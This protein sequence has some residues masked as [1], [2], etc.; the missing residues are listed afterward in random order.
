MATVLNTTK[1]LPGSKSYH[2][3]PRF[4]KDILDQVEG[5]EWTLAR[6]KDLDGMVDQYHLDSAIAVADTLKELGNNPE[7]ND[8][9]NYVVDLEEL[10]KLLTNNLLQIRRECM[11]ASKNVMELGNKWDRA[12]IAEMFENC[13]DI[14]QQ[15][16]CCSGGVREILVSRGWTEKCMTNLN[17]LFP[18][19][20]WK[21]LGI[22]DHSEA[23][24]LVAGIPGWM[25]ISDTHLK[26][27]NKDLGATLTVKNNYGD[28]SIIFQQKDK[29]TI[30][31]DFYKMKDIFM[32]I[33]SPTQDEI[34]TYKMATGDDYDI[35]NLRDIFYS[36]RS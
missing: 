34:L 14:A 5:L 1:L 33:T 20:G 31:Y 2:D 12:D 17:A 29:K 6:I 18:G 13:A 9:Y 4:D 7:F 15:E 19:I 30:F 23:E 10:V 32:D 22:L 27:E 25:S 36:E 16:L 24:H 3:T 21:R 26:M 35:S 28:L 11:K 8:Y